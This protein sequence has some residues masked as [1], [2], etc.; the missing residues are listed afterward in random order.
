VKIGV[1]RWQIK[2]PAFCGALLRRGGSNS[3]PPAGGYEPGI[4][5]YLPA[6]KSI[7]GPLLTLIPFLD[8]LHLP[9]FQKSLYELFPRAGIESSSL[10]SQV[11]YAI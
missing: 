6:A 4:I 3:R 5:S 11:H 8:A 10:F 1:N 9:Y 2:N 7:H